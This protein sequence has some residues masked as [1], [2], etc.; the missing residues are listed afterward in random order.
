MGKKKTILEEKEL[1][2]LGVPFPD[3][4]EHCFQHPSDSADDSASAYMRAVD[5]A[6]E[7]GD[8]L[9]AHLWQRA[10]EI[11]LRAGRGNVNAVASDAREDGMRQGFE[12]G[13]SDGLKE[14]LSEGKRVGFVAGREFGEKRAAKLSSS[15]GVLFATGTDSSPLDS[16]VVPPARSL[17]H[18]ATQTDRAVD[19]IIPTA[20]AIVPVAIT[21]SITRA[22]ARS[23][24]DHRAYAPDQPPPSPPAPSPAAALHAPVQANAAPVPVVPSISPSPPFSWADDPSP[25][26]SRIPLLPPRDFSA[27]RSEAPTST[28]FSTLRYRAHRRHR[29]TRAPHFHV[30]CSSLHSR[31][32]KSNPPFRSSASKVTFTTT[33]TLDWDRDPPTFRLESRFALHGMEKGRG[34]GLM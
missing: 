8:T 12:L 19:T 31:P 18:V 27:L 3:E 33:S 23:W 30:S 14:G 1:R 5:F 28:P 4:L 2:A 26:L 10:L 16:S 13:R 34:R 29:S 21:P 17:V 15:V 22:P 24:V 7:L 11:G 20:V 32:A 9:A 6:A 25:D